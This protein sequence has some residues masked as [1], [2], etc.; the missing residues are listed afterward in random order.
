MRSGEDL[1]DLSVTAQTK[2]NN[3]EEFQYIIFSTQYA[4]TKK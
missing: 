3:E 2:R 1:F 4:I